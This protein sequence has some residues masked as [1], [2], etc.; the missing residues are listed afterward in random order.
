VDIEVYTC[1]GRLNLF[2]ELVIKRASC[3]REL[4][5]VFSLRY[6]VYCI[7]RGY[8]R[9]DDHPD[10]LEHDE[11]DPHSVHF[12]AYLNSSPVGT[13]RLILRNPFGFPVER[14]CN[15]NLRTIC[16]DADQVA[17]ISRLAVS[18]SA[19][20]RLF[21]ER[22]KITLSLI[23]ELYYTSRELRIRYL[24][25]AMSKSLERLLHRCGM[26]FMKAGLPVDYHGLRTPYYA[27]CDDLEREVFDR[28]RD[29]FEFLFPTY[30]N[31]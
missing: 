1:T 26:S 2:M 14:Y 19:A 6:K 25:C 17:E 28:R 4:N 22:S 31:S 29:I 12:I 13:V 7:E 30:V 24:V 10:G 18:S 15:A 8:E 11:Y 9:T 21:I 5:D 3:K 27:A 20:K 23:K 16:Q